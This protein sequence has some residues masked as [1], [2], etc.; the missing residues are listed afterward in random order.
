MSLAGIEIYKDGGVTPVCSFSGGG[1]EY[2]RTTKT[3]NHCTIN[4]DDGIYMSDANPSNSQVYG[5]DGYEFI[6]DAVCWNDDGSTIDVYVSL[7]KR[8]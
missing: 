1:I 2:I 4:D 5:A 8:W 7:G 3:I 6:I